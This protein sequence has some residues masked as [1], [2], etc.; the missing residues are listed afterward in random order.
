MPL[1]HVAAYY[2]RRFCEQRRARHDRE[3]QLA[4]QWHLLFGRTDQSKLLSIQPEGLRKIIAPPDSYWADPF[5]WQRKGEFFVFCEEVFYRE[6]KGHISVIQ[7]DEKGG[8]VAPSRIV[9]E[10]PHHLSYPFLFEF[11]GTLYMLPESGFANVLNLYRCAEFPYRWEKVGPIFEDVQYYD[12]TLLEHGGRWWLFVTVRNPRRLQLPDHDLLVFSAESPIA[13]KWTPH[14]ANPVLRSFRRAR[15]AGRIFSQDGRLYRP[16]QN[17]LLRYGASLNLNEIVHLDAENYR[18]RLVR[19]IKPVGESNY[20]CLH[21]LDW[22]EG[23]A[24]MDT[25][26]MVPE[27]EIQR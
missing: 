27:A 9:V 18:E 1:F 26:R 6:G 24:L 22:H 17:S 3:H 13:G 10:E 14:P 11:D 12:P 16:S 5:G 25:Q 20:V 2:F 4:G 7:L 23:V 19:E 8:I 21:H 15:P